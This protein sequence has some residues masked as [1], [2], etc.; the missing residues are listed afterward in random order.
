MLVVTVCGLG[1]LR[2][3]PGSWGS[4]PPAIIAA[5]LI[6]FEAPF[7]LTNTVLLAIAALSSIAC[8]RLGSWAERRFHGKDPGVV[9][10]DETAGMAAAL[11]L[12]PRIL[13]ATSGLPASE[14]TGYLIIAASFI[15][16]RIFDIIKAPPANL[17]QQ[18]P[19][20]WG[21]LLDDL[22]AAL[23]ANLLLQI[24]LRLVLPSLIGGP[25]GI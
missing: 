12:L 17:M 10:I 24:A 11:L 16:F 5:I 8:V 3:A 18:F 14:A 19:A 4:L 25:N 9:V 21:I 22:V 1:K 15:L 7:W 20:G 13:P 6:A 23:Y 2:P